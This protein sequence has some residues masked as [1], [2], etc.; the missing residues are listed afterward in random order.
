MKP[1]CYVKGEGE[2]FMQNMSV[3]TKGV[4]KP[5]APPVV[6]KPPTP[7][8]TPSKSPLPKLETAVSV[9]SININDKP[10]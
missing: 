8:K 3:P 5:P 4:D 7:V 6:E 10:A 2:T 9:M 1:I